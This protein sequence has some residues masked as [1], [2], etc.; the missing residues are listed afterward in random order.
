MMVG[1]QRHNFAVLSSEPVAKRGAVGW[2]ATDKTL[3][4]CPARV[5]TQVAVEPSGE[6]RHNFAVF[7]KE[8]V[9]KRGAVGWNAT[10]IT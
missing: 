5:A 6:K 7:P 3:L 10:D 9:A 1:I 4:L 8:P 2:N